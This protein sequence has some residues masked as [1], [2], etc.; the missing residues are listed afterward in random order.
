[1]KNRILLTFI[2]ALSFTISS[3]RQLI[4]DT[5]SAAAFPIV[6]NHSAVTLYVDTNDYTVVK[7]AATLLQQDIDSVT[8]VKPLVTHTL[9]SS[10]N[11]IVIG[12]IGKSALIDQLAAQKRTSI[13]SLSNKWEA[14]SIQVVQHPFNGIDNAL[15]IA[16]SDRRGTAYGV[17]ELS[18]QMG[19]S[20]W[21]YWADVPVKKKATLYYTGGR[22]YNAPAVKYRGIFLNDEAPALSGWSKEKFGGFNHLFYEKV[23]ELILRLKGNY[24]WPAMWGN[25]FYDDDTLNPKLA[26]DYGIVMGTSHHEPLGRAHDEW[27]RYG[28]GPWT[29]DSNAVNLQAFWR[30]G[31]KR[32]HGREN[33]V[34]IG[35]RGNGDEPMTEGTAIALLERIVKDQRQIIAE[36]TGKPASETPQLWALYKEVQDYY[37]KGMRV[38][39]DVTL[40]LSDDNWGNIR[41]L[42][43]LNSKPRSGGYGIYYHFDYVGDPRNYKWINTNPIARVWEQMHLAYQYGVD[44]IWIV[45]VGDLKPM[46][47]PIQFFLDYAWNPD[48]YGAKDLFPYTEHWAANQ[49]GGT[50]AKS[51]ANIV[52]T[53]LQYSSRRKPEL[54]SPETYS[55]INY[56]EADRI[57]EEYTKL[58]ASAD[59]INRL[60]PTRYR[61]AYYE[62]V[63]HP[64]KASANL[65]ELYVTV[66]KNRLYAKQ[67]RAGTNGY[68][69][70]AKQLYLKDSLISRYYN[71]TLAGGKWRHMMDQ[72]HIGYTYWQQPETNVMPA[73]N[74]I[75]VPVRAAMGIA[76]EGDSSLVDNRLSLPVF[77]TYCPQMHYID[78]FNKG[79]TPFDY[80]IT[81]NTPYI[82]LSAGKGRITAEKRVWIS[83]IPQKA[84]AGIHTVP[85]TISGAGAKRIVYI[86]VNKPAVDIDSVKGFVEADGVVAIEAAHYT[87]MVNKDSVTWQT[88]P[89]FGR[90]LSGI[91]TFPVTAASEIPSASTPHLEYQLYMQD[92]G[93]VQIHAYLSPTLPFHNDGLRYAISLD[94]E[95]PQIINMNEGYSEA[96][97]RKWVADNIID[98]TSTHHISTPGPHILKFWRVDA[99]VVL[100]KLVVDA[101]GLKES[102]LGPPESCH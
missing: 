58:L 60:L 90:T 12:T 23:F 39:D 4:S 10:K 96:I 19:V 35:M 66:A 15:V 70:K 6:V 1:M 84:P 48:K 61:N 54:L 93:D 30:Q 81:G 5:E 63:L 62:L 34:S 36:E 7:K 97:W 26:D 21:Y 75:P 33:I 95:T 45:N 101:G 25:A 76:V 24:L 13:D 68:A 9:P 46:E 86:Q 38:P 14:Y 100:Q 52:T 41:K 53:Y 2:T 80:T 67:G 69:D 28:K 59:S 83:I 50:Y 40:L 27:R 64:V 74:H 18:Q 71:D 73:V 47:F 49:F 102:Y 22:V 85:L 57:V 32:M 92:T 16:G 43:N 56:R 72:T 91:T 44:K 94:D 8:G 99:G 11:I 77:D 87:N 55:L 29:Y 78:I 17:F 98:K 42:P 51:I 31:V 88:V 79:K 65:N 82:K 89:Y 3:A 37:D 20:P